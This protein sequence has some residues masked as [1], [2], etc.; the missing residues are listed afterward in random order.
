MSSSTV[1]EWLNLFLIPGIG[2]NVILKL[3][4]R[5][6]SP[7]EV[8]TA[9]ESELANVVGYSYA[10]ILSY[11]RETV[12]LDG[13]L[14]KIDKHEVKIITLDDSDYPVSLAELYDPPMVLYVKGE[15]KPTD[16][17]SVSIV[18]TRNCSPYGAKVT[19]YFS[20]G[21]A[22]VGI[23]IVSG[24]AIGVDGIAHKSALSA[25][26]RTIAFL[27]S[28]IDVIYPSKH[29]QLFSEIKDNGAVISTF[30]MGTQPVGK[31]FPIRNRFISGF[32][33]GTIVTEATLSS[34][35]LITA[36]YAVEQGKT[37][38]AVPGP[39]GYPGSEGPHWLINQGAKLVEKSSDII[40]EVPN[41]LKD[42]LIS[43]KT[44]PPGP[45]FDRL[46][47][48]ANSNLSDKSHSAGSKKDISRLETQSENN[49]ST[50]KGSFSGIH[51]I[52]PQ[53]QKILSVLS[54]NGSY[55]DEVALSCNI[56]VSEALSLLTMMEMKGLV[57]QFSGKRF[58]K[59]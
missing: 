8:L 54:P 7:K 17:Y 29:E 6:G 45:D 47:S 48:P 18:G 34:G 57:T 56:P 24:L 4:A 32:S 43:C 10:R 42:Y 20:R 35:A 16:L 31:N 1:R 59:A 3:V 44:T 5:F 46:S 22:E 38:F 33:F 36:K 53:E 12:D 52:S 58:A 39:I 40:E 37:V 19:E 25:G 15:L 50:S 26:G 51:N 27:G 55:V 49:S 30:P 11:Y 41:Y 14:K 2:S 23:T 28:G 13:E 21:L 9:S